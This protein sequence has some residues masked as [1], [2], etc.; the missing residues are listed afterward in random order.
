MVEGKVQAAKAMVRTKSGNDTIK[1]VMTAF[2]E[3][4]SL[5]QFSTY[6]A[7]DSAQIL[8]STSEGSR[9]R[10]VRKATFMQ[11]G[12]LLELEQMQREF[13]PEEAAAAE[14]FFQHF[15]SQEFRLQALTK[16]S[17]IQLALD[18]LKVFGVDVSKQQA[19]LDSWK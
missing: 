17:D 6:D 2:R 16:A 4:P 15:Y 11:L 8:D 19:E 12:N 5:Q 9:R 10:W 3:E 1:R 13:S 14:R 18:T 7:T